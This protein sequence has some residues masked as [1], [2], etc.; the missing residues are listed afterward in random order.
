M[1]QAGSGKLSDVVKDIF[2]FLGIAPR[3]E[4]ISCFA[5]GGKL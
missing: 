4:K 1:H 3:A 2:S 5:S